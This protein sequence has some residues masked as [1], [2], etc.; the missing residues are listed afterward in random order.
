MEKESIY[1]YLRALKNTRVLVTG[2]SPLTLSVNGCADLDEFQ[3][4]L[5]DQQF[6]ALEYCA[7][8]VQAR[9]DN[10]GRIKILLATLRG[11]RNTILLDKDGRPRRPLLRMEEG[12]EKNPRSGRLAAPGSGAIRGRAAGLGGAG[13]GGPFARA[14]RV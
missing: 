13:L 11:I 3:E 5:F 1:A 7:G 8:L 6:A 14:A 12:G 4:Q 10:A 2:R 9:E